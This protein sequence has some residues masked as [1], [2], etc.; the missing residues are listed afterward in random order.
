MDVTDDEETIILAARTPVSQSRSD[1]QEKTSDDQDDVASSPT[2][3]DK[4]KVASI[5]SDDGDH[6]AN[7]RT[8]VVSLESSPDP[9][10][11][12]ASTEKSR[13]E[14]ARLQRRVEVLKERCTALGKQCDENMTRA[15]AA[16][17]E[18]K[19]TVE[20][21]RKKVAE[22]LRTVKEEYKASHLEE[23]TNLKARH[24]QEVKRLK[25]E[26]AAR[27]TLLREKGQE[28]ID[29]LKGERAAERTELTEMKKQLKSEQQAEI[30][31]SKPEHS[32]VVKEKDKTIKELIEQLQKTTDNSKEY[33]ATA[34]KVRIQ[35]DDQVTRTAEH[36]AQMAEM[37]N[38]ITDLNEKIVASKAEMTKHGA[39][40]Q[41]DYNLHTETKRKLTQYQ[42]ANFAMRLGVDCRDKEIADLRAGLHGV[43]V[44]QVA[45][46]GK[47]LEV[48]QQVLDPYLNG[49]PVITSIEQG[50]S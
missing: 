39:R 24:E 45:V 27:F 6:E 38:V 47:G 21:K 20:D 25:A 5:Q 49:E 36:A 35:L 9:T 2:V 31:E 3:S 41:L 44:Y 33:K 22:V 42:R 13:Q 46:G 15:L 48:G 34:D 8:L 32:K 1:E 4:T 14:I 17:I 12:V 26:H 18:V 40:R 19:A 23:V 43:G 30:R 28:K 10:A 50:G 7:D 37:E 16:E 29:E 11:G